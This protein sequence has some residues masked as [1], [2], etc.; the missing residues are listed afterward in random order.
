MEVKEVYDS[1]VSKIADLL[2]RQVEQSVK[3]E[4]N[5]T[6]VQLPIK[7]IILAGGFGQHPYVVESL[8]ER[9]YQRERTESCKES[10]NIP[11]F[12]A[13]W[14][15]L[16]GSNPEDK[17]NQYFK[18]NVP[19]NQVPNVKKVKVLKVDLQRLPKKCA[20]Y[21]KRKEKRGYYQIAYEL[22]MTAILIEGKIK[23]KFAI[24][25][26][27]DDCF[28]AQF[29]KQSEACMNYSE[30]NSL[31]YR[32]QNPAPHLFGMEKDMDTTEE[33]DTERET[34][35]DEGEE[36][37]VTDSEDE[38]AVVKEIDVDQDDDEAAGPQLNKQNKSD[39]GVRLL[40]PPYVYR[41]ATSHLQ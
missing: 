14:S 13:T 30:L 31:T 26:G 12:A 6:P 16:L 20:K 21:E 36:P 9:V 33:S 24:V 35:V 19:L 18:E 17:S 29:E 23:M 37:N 22:K 7:R 38:E 1:C 27:P 25:A 10:Y 41:Q 11:V 8:A 3:F 32:R 4:P 34:P 5:D 15:H 40:H 39:N 2:K 28:R